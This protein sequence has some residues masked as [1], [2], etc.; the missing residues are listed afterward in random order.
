MVNCW[1]IQEL[2]LKCMQINQIIM[3][4]HLTLKHRIELL[5]AILNNQQSISNSA[6]CY[7]V[8]SLVGFG[9]CGERHPR[10]PSNFHDFKLLDFTMDFLHPAGVFIFQ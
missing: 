3:T 7:N 10:K 8:P 5:L 9:H 2:V 6:L 4:Y 1:K